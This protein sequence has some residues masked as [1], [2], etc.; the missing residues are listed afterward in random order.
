MTFDRL[1]WLAPYDEWVDE[2]IGPLSNGHFHV[3]V[4]G[5][6]CPRGAQYAGIE[7]QVWASG[8]HNSIPEIVAHLFGK[9]GT[10]AW[11][12]DPNDYDHFRGAVT[13]F[14]C[15][16]LPEEVPPFAHRLFERVHQLEQGLHAARGA[17][18]H[19][20]RRCGNT[21][22]RR[23]WLR[24]RR[25]SAG[26]LLSFRSEY[27]AMFDERLEGIPAEDL[28]AWTKDFADD[29]AK[30][31]DYVAEDWRDQPPPTERSADEN[32]D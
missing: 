11:N 28:L 19:L 17:R 26:R 9:H 15:V 2:F 23:P 14:P 13:V 22:A 4:K 5:C 20:E 27:R 1:R 16:D 7:S 8:E 12:G 3:H 31:S 21:R 29:V 18:R 24:P 32:H 25:T 10:D 30:A 6:D